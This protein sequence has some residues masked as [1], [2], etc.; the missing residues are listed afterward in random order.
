MCGKGLRGESGKRLKLGSPGERQKI[1]ISSFSS[2][3]EKDFLPS[4]IR[5]YCCKA[6]QHQSPAWQFIISWVSGSQFLVALQTQPWRESGGCSLSSS[7]CLYGQS[8][9]ALLSHCQD[10]S[11]FRKSANETQPCSRIPGGTL[12]FWSITTLEANGLVP[13]WEDTWPKASSVSAFSPLFHSY[14]S[15]MGQTKLE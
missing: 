8:H 11:A 14:L 10:T 4:Q 1:A 13:S 3:S 12:G 15:F 7:P 2:L 5:V 6:C 9:L